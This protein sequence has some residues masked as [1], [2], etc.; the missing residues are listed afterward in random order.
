[1]STQLYNQQKNNITSALQK[2]RNIN[3]AGLSSDPGSGKALIPY[4]LAKDLV[5]TVRYLNPIPGL[6]NMFPMSADG[7][8]NSDKYEWNSVTGLRAPGNYA[9]ERAN[10]TAL[11]FQS[12]RQSRYL[13]VRK[14][15][16]SIWRFIENVTK[17]QYDPITLSLMNEARASAL[18]FAISVLYDNAYAFND[19]TVKNLGAY[20]DSLDTSI[21]NRVQL[22]TAG[23]PTVL[24]TQMLDSALVRSNIAAGFQGNYNTRKRVW[25]MSPSM[26]TKVRDLIT[27]GNV[28]F[29][30]P[31]PNEPEIPNPFLVH[32]GFYAGSYA[33]VPIVE[34]QGLGGINAGTMGTVTT[35][36]VVAASSLA[37]KTYWIKVSKVAISVGSVA[38]ANAIGETMC[39]TAVSQAIAGATET[40]RLTVPADPNALYYKVYMTDTA[41]TAANY[42]LAGVY[43]ARTLN[44]DGDVVG[45]VTQGYVTSDANGN[46]VNID[47]VFDRATATDAQLLTVGVT[48]D[49]K[50]DLPLTVTSGINGENIILWDIEPREGAGDFIYADESPDQD[51][52][53][54][55]MLQLAQIADRTDFLLYSN[56]SPIFRYPQASVMLRNVRPA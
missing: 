26:A 46:V 27:L 25:L 41:D 11:T 12:Q 14:T 15:K 10:P 16:I 38:S 35:S 3:K 2:L 43:K 40:L 37:A 42:R 48:S 24:T 30:F 33:G 19:A 22:D 56:G 50:N 1:M 8:N 29:N 39:S 44:S 28:R 5:N 13:K 47:L 55:T 21:A 17:G 18:D 49:M 7:Q 54:M 52:G 6:M 23:A 4:H 53:F 45:S 31:V 34:I 20:E 32:S 9:A 36:A 51:A